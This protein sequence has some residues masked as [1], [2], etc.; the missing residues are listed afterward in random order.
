MDS[1]R[2]IMLLTALSA[3]LIAVSRTFAAPSETR[4]SLVLEN[5]YVSVSFD[6]KTGAM[7]RLV[8]KT[9]GWNI[10]EREFLGQSFE[11]LLPM[12]GPEFTDEDRGYN[13]VKGIEQVPPEIKVGDG[14]ITFIWKGMRTP[15]MKS[16]ADIEFRGTVSLTERGLEFTGDVINN[17]GYRV[18]YVSWPCIGEVSVPDRKQFFLQNTRNDFREL[19]PH[20]N[21]Q[22]GYW[23]VEWPTSTA[24]LNEKS[25]LQVNDNDQGFIVFHK[26]VPQH[27]TI[28]SFELIPGLETRYT[29]PYDSEIDGVPVRIQFKVNNCIYAQP[30]ERKAL[31]P[32]TFVTYKGPWTAGVDLFKDLKE[33]CI[34]DSGSASSTPEWVDSPLTW[35]KAGIS[36]RA[37]ELLRVARESVAA[38]VDV[39]LIGGW[40][41]ISSG[42]PFEVPDLGPAIAECQAMG[43][44]VVLETSWTRVNRHSPVYMEEYRGYI[45]SDP[46]GVP[47]H[48]EW[49]CPGSSHVRETVYRMWNRLPALKAADGY[50][51]RDHNHDDRTFSCFDPDHD[52]SYG[53]PSVN[54]MMALDK[55]M[56]KELCE[57]EGKAS[58][59]YGFLEWQNLLYDGYV[60]D[61]AE[62]MY[63]RHRYISPDEPMLLKVDVRNAR[64]LI[65]KAVLYRLNIVYDLNFYNSRLSDYPHITEYGRMVEDFRNAFADRIWNASW[66]DHNG[67]SVLGHDIEWSVF[68]DKDGKRSVVLANMNVNNASEAFVSFEDP[69]ELLAVSPEKMNPEPFN[70]NVSVAPLSTVVIFEK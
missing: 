40:Y 10:L 51:N 49:L 22:H 35:R 4:E 18:E 59:G 45:M 31:D 62:E 43:L 42:V 27:I 21:N 5:E 2:K 64:R 29:N 8:D 34:A 16:P 55:V 57:K 11:L 32:V 1:C 60:L 3:M 56:E 44:K 69:G 46:Y 58:F 61:V 14:E 52:H 65:N 19:S 67:A 20:F 70:G 26:E 41:D 24:I 23:G 50:M 36:G 37:D 53:A 48:F 12:D 68:M 9:S 17:S 25:Y 15:Y 47:Y 38:G 28:T 39:L 63:P 54:G 33:S 30:G 66:Q 13:V 6:P 7:T